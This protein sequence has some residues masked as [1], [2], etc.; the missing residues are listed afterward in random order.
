M[1]LWGRSLSGRRESESFCGP[2]CV[3]CQSWHRSLSLQLLFTVSTV[4]SPLRG[5]FMV[6]WNRRLAPAAT[7]CRPFA[8]ELV[9]RPA[10]YSYSEKVNCYPFKDSW[11]EPY[12]CCTLAAR[13]CSV[14]PNSCLFYL[15]MVI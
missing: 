4:M 11:S 13:V 12:G 7:S 5:F 9:R 15:L 2:V 1:G 10:P 3:L 6:A 14:N 8:A